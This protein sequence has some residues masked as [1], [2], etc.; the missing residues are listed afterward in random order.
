[1]TQLTSSVAEFPPSVLPPYSLREPQLNGVQ[2]MHYQ[3]HFH[4]FLII[5]TTVSPFLFLRL[6]QI[7]PVSPLREQMKY[8]FSLLCLLCLPSILFFLSSLKHKSFSGL[9][10]LSTSLGGCLM[11]LCA[12]HPLFCLF[13]NLLLY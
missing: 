4:H 3:L 6:H 10:K 13:I 11:F 12:S 7:L 5:S 1:M 2:S 9:F 8:N